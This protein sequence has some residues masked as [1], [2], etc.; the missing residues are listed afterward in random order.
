MQFL[1]HWETRFKANFKG[2]FRI[3]AEIPLSAHEL[4][5]LLDC[6]KNYLGTFNNF[7]EATRTFTDRYPFTFLTL[8]AHY[9]SLNEQR[10]YWINLRERLGINQPLH[11]Q[12]WHQIF[13]KEAKKLGLKTVETESRNAYIPTIRFHGGIPAYYLPDFFNYIIKPAVRDENSNSLSKSE[14]LEQLKVKALI[15]NPISDFL[16]NSG[17]MG[18]A[19]FDECCNLVKH[20]DAN[21]GEILPFSQVKEIPWFV[22]SYMEHFIEDDQDGAYKWKRPTLELV[23]GDLP[24][25]I[26]LPSQINIPREISSKGLFWQI[27]WQ[28]HEEPEVIVCDLFLGGSGKYTKEESKLVP[29]PLEMITITINSGSPNDEPS[30]ELRRWRIPLLPPSDQAPILAFRENYKILSNTQTLPSKCLYLLTPSRTNYEVEGEIV[31][32]VSYTISGQGWNDWCLKS[33][34]LEKANVLLFHRDGKELGKPIPVVG[35]IPEPELFGNSHFEYQINSNIPLFIGEAPYLRV[36]YEN[37][38]QLDNWQ[39]WKLSISSIGETLPIIDKNISLK[40]YEHWIEFED[41]FFRFPISA[42][43]VGEAYGEYEVGL[44]IPRKAQSKI[45]FYIWD[46][47]EISD[48]YQEVPFPEDSRSST[49]DFII[50]LNK[51]SE[52]I[53]SDE[54]GSIEIIKLDDTFMISS[55]SGLLFVELDLITPSKYSMVSVPL[56]LPIYRLKWGLSAEDLPLQLNQDLIHLSKEVF[57]QKASSLVQLEMFNLTQIQ[58]QLSCELVEIENEN[59]VYKSVKFTRPSIN[60]NR[61]SFPLQDF[62]QSVRD[63]HVPAQIQLVCQKDPQTQIRYALIEVNPEI[64]IENVNLEKIGETDWKITWRESYPL[65]HRRLLIRSVWQPW[66]SSQAFHIPD[67]NRGELVLRNLGLPPSLYEFFFYVRRSWVALSTDVPNDGKCHQINLIPADERLKALNIEPKNRDEAFKQSIERACI[68]DSTD[69]LEERDLA[70]SHAARHI[71]YV[72]NVHVLVESMSWLESISNQ[73]AGI[74]AI[75][76]MAFDPKLV[77]FFVN[78]YKGDLSQLKPY[79]QMVHNWILPES[80]RMLLSVISEKK[81]ILTCLR[82]LRDNDAEDFIDRMM[83]Q[84]IYK[85]ISFDAAYF[86]LTEKKDNNLMYVKQLT[87]MPIFAES[88]ELLSKLISELIQNNR[89]LQEEWLFPSL[90]RLTKTEVS[91]SLLFD[92]FNILI[93]VDFPETWKTLIECQNSSKLSPKDFFTLLCVKPDK[94]FYFLRNSNQDG[95]YDDILV[96]LQ[97]KFPTAA[98]LLKIGMSISTPCGD[99]EIISIILNDCKSSEQVYVSDHNF[100]LRLQNGTGK[101]RINLEADFEKMSLKTSGEKAICLCTECKEYFNFQNE[102]L[103]HY[104]TAHPKTQAKGFIQMT[105]QRAFTFDDETY[106]IKIN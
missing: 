71:I 67:D 97:D 51:N 65:K 77:R 63:L 60:S 64:Q 37:N 28:D 101:N 74:N 25:M 12:G 49:V 98:K 80:A 99:A 48:Y 19:W 50:K 88:D 4:K 76:R 14:L 62:E 84:V 106:S 26:K 72:E 30:N 56:H 8:L 68:M 95:R 7:A 47:L 59:N 75:R 45:R 93:E 24:V 41:G 46:E 10:N 21:H 32:Y 43:L 85:N 69:Q 102:V 82:V 44:Q 103:A 3:I 31:E 92:Y 90:L 29:Q 66:Q 79:L 34:D 40:D 9:S 96:Q 78:R 100:C 17:E 36:P 81:P 104:Q 18:L 57:I 2:T 73:P 13:L 91:N 42:L 94:A 11:T 87:N 86:L 52:V 27:T 23:D 16:D 58:N 89:I 54:A 22:Y 38:S 5:E 55:S 6:V 35:E 105:G 53:K 61:L 70:I 83:E 1:D 33:V 20:A 15:A 39:D